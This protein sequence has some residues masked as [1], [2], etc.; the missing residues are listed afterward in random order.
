MSLGGTPG[1]FNAS[2]NQKPNYTELLHLP[3]LLACGQSTS[4]AC[5]GG[6]RTILDEIY[7]LDL[8]NPQDALSFL[9][10]VLMHVIDFSGSSRDDWISIAYNWI[11]K[12]RALLTSHGFIILKAIQG[13]IMMCSIRD[14]MINNWLNM[15]T[16]RDDLRIGNIQRFK[17]QVLRAHHAH[18]LSSV[19][20]VP[21]SETFRSCIGQG[22]SSVTSALYACTPW[23]EFAPGI[24]FVYIPSLNTIE[25]DLT[26]YSQLLP[27]SICNLHGIEPVPLVVPKEFDDL[28][29]EVD[30]NL[31]SYC[32]SVLILG[33]EA[34]FTKAVR[35]V[36]FKASIMT[37]A[38]IMPAHAMISFSSKDPEWHHIDVDND[39]LLK[40]LQMTCPV[41]GLV[42]PSLTGVIEMCS[43]YIHLYQSLRD[44]V[45]GKTTQ[46]HEFVHL[47]AP[48]LQTPESQPATK[49]RDLNQSWRSGGGLL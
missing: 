1:P 35:T 41:A 8:M 28:N 9:R 44:V 39:A 32:M 46:K 17:M 19:T 30:I 2:Y 49:T 40:E 21:S 4:I 37:W 6:T 15:Q 34:V 22:P 5:T 18:A 24:C 14:I 36:R 7:G 33:E 25:I 16:D 20:F 12:S 13:A 48:F 10:H 47:D 31:F 3:H 42:L 38:R 11:S 26:V 29:S 43:R 27:V 45:D 23:M